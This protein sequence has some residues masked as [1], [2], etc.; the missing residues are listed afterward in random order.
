MKTIL[1]FLLLVLGPAVWGAESELIPHNKENLSVR[2]EVQLAISK[3]AAWLR[4]QQSADG[5]WSTPDQPAMTGLALTALLRDPSA[6]QDQAGVIAKGYDY[7]LR[8]VQPD[9]GIYAKGL[10]NYNTSISLVALILAN[11]PKYKTVIANARGFIVGQQAKNL[12]DPELNGGIGYGPTGTSRGHPDLS[13][14]VM[15]LEALSY[16]KKAKPAAELAA[17]K[18]LDLPAA[19]A[20]IQRCQNL[21]EYNKETWASDDPQNKGGFVYFPGS[22][23]AGET[24]LPSGKTALRSYGSM[25][26]AGLLSYIYADLKKDDPRVKAALDWLRKNYSLS[27][28]PGLGQEGLFYYYQVMG[29]ALAAAGLDK[30]EASDG[31][32]IDWK[33]DLALKLINLEKPDGSWANESGRWMEKDPALVTSYALITLEVIY[34]AM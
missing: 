8:N 7:L 15:A 26:Y 25:S 29:K 32:K 3:G 33:S 21:P 13:N 1:F 28:N 14:T 27:E 20:F 12:S 16:S 34:G 9:G 22:S 4:K 18:E 17:T 24:Q 31:K 5:S 11:D 10:A 6:P 2:N 23:M 19:I 30:L